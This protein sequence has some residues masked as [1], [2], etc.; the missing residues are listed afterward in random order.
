MYSFITGKAGVGKTYQVR[1]MIKKS[2]SYGVMCSSTGISAI[3]L[4]EGVT[5]LNSLLGYF[6]TESLADVFITGRLQQR[7]RRIRNS[8]ENIII[9]EC[10][11][12]SAEQLD[13]ICQALNQVNSSVTE[14]PLGL[15]LVGDY[16]QLQPVDGSLGFKA[17]SWPL[18]E[19]NIKLLTK[20][21]RQA[22]IPFIEAL[23]FA[24]YGKGLALLEKLKELKVEFYT[25]VDTS[26]QGTTMFAKNEQVKNYNSYRL[27]KL[28]GRKICST[29]EV[30]GLQLKEWTKHIPSV[31]DLKLGA[32]I[33]ILTNKS[34]GYDNE[35]EH[36]GFEYVNGD[37]GY[38]RD[39]KDDVFFIELV[40]NKKIVEVGKLIR[41]NESK[42]KPD[43]FTQLPTGYEAFYNNERKR[44]ILGEVECHP[45]RLAWAT[46]VHKAQGLTL[47]KIQLDIRNHFFGLDQMLYVA[48]SRGRTIEGLRLIA[49]KEQLV[50][51]RCN[52]DIKVV[53]FYNNLIKR[54]S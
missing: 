11:M 41:Y 29:K 30:K 23:E 35:G 31:L 8:Y 18:F 48:F 4:G 7:L 28:P 43:I 27:L 1:E 5:T 13:I 38:V 19:N 3:N 20:V 16:A 34:L 42:H 54:L 36:L 40:R 37:C 51:K 22:S 15:V 2:P 26:Y 32:Y 49:T 47:D 50:V 44:W 10:S 6:D 52:A 12:V 17:E 39:F 45:I 14:E 25:D 53:S 33:M 21:W 9:D 24:R 46:T